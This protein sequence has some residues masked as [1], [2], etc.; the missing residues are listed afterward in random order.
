MG[1]RVQHIAKKKNLCGKSVEEGG[2]EDDGN[3]RGKG[4]YILSKDGK[5][6]LTGLETDA[7][8][9]QGRGKIGRSPHK[10]QKR[11]G[12]VKTCWRP[13]T[14]GGGGNRTERDRE[15]YESVGRCTKE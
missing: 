4:V 9:P 8:D 12:A 5:K 6:K 3:D 13:K 7:K 1:A 11:L 2:A 14:G 10:G 15:L